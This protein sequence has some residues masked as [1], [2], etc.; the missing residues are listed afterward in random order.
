VR[1]LINLP[2][3]P[4][5]AHAVRERLQ[6]TLSASYTIE[7]ELGGG[8]MSRVFVAEELTL[9]R[10]VVIKVLPDAMAGQVS[11]E[12]FKR[13]IGLAATLQ[14]PHI[15][16]LLT[17]GEADGLPYFTMPY[18]DG[19]SLRGRLTR[20]GELPIGE[21]IRM[22]REVASALAY[23]HERGVVHRDIKPDNVLITGGS[24]MVTDFGVAKALS[25]SSHT[26]GTGITSVG[27]ALGT[28][29]YMAPEQAAADPQVDHRADIYAFGAM[30]YEM[31]TGQPPF[32][33]RSHQ[34]LLAAHVMETPETIERR[35]AGMPVPLAQLV[36]RCLAKRPA[37]RP[38]SAQEIIQSLDTI[39]TPTGGLTPTGMRYA[40]PRSKRSIAV[41][42]AVGVIG[43]GAVALAIRAARSSFTP[44]QRGNVHPVAAVDGEIELDPAISPDGLQVVYTARK[45][46]IFRLYVSQVGEPSRPLLTED[47]GGDQLSPR[48]SPDGLHIVFA[49]NG[50]GYVVAS[51]GGAALRAIESP[52]HSVSTPNWSPDSKQYVYA[53]SAGIA[54]Q[55]VTGGPAQYVVKEGVFLHGPVWSP[56]GT[57]LAYVVN[58]PRSLG[59][60]STN[61]IWVVSLKNGRALG[62]PQRVS[63]AVHVNTSPAWAPDSRSLFYLSNPHGATELFQQEVRSDGSPVG[64][65]HLISDALNGFSITLSKLGDRIAYDIVADQTS[66][67]ATAIPERGYATT[68]AAQQVTKQKEHI[69]ALSLSRDGKWLTYDSDREGNSNI[70]KV[71]VTGGDAVRLTSD[72]GN[73]FMPGWSPDG[74]EIAYYSTRSGHRHIYAMSADGN[75]EVQVTRGPQE[76]F[77]PRWSPDGNSLVFMS[78]V[79]DTNIRQ[80][81]V[82]TR[83]ANRQWSQPR[84]I[85]PDSL[86]NVGFVS[87]WSPDG[88][89]IAFTTD[90]TVELVP[91]SGGIPT[92]IADSA[93]LAGGQPA[94][95]IWVAKDAAIYVRMYTRP[96]RILSIPAGG[97]KPRTILEEDPAHPLAWYGFASDGHQ[98]FFTLG[99]RWESS[100]S[101]MDLKY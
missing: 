46:S 88:T 15:V 86:Q 48:W 22:L 77:A 47:L 95:V 82:T 87:A 59:N 79:A 24:A 85:T 62:R 35:R 32:V 81:Y 74:Q 14:H 16:P 99:P 30:A 97:G 23:A 90:R 63:D 28:P 5:E 94:D 7:R 57:R 76:D 67:W 3:P 10:R 55:P 25:A 84:R 72:S 69:E 37:D 36:M 56:D 20:G 17:A 11:I 83:D 89:Q 60:S 98:V 51:A 96:A 43:L 58:R 1:Q 13:E 50:T 31:L 49:V 80:L 42:V 101:V 78:Q 44:Y 91:S 38:Q 33:G 93:T 70:Y 8:G 12:R 75:G 27:V 53:D 26:P 100:I 41:L 19:E 21:T 40:P 54:V 45:D 52:T 65:L 61:T 64:G 29:A 71:R 18:I 6:Q 2:P 34:A 66:I 73:A 4:D 92:M 39:S 68:T 9:K